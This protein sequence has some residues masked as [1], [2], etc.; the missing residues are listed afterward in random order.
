LH[1]KEK[2]AKIDV[3]KLESLKDGVRA[4]KSQRENS[5]DHLGF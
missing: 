5:R 1:I 2:T 4:Q 3:E